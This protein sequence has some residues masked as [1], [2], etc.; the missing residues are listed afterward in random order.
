MSSMGYAGRPPSLT[1]SSYRS[2][3]STSEGVP[4]CVE[5]ALEGNGEGEDRPGAD[6]AATF[7]KRVLNSLRSSG[8]GLA[9]LVSW[10]ALSLPGTVR[11]LRVQRTVGRCDKTTEGTLYLRRWMKRSGRF[12]GSSTSIS[13]SS[14][15]WA[16]LSV[17]ASRYRSNSASVKATRS[18]ARTTGRLEEGSPILPFTA[19]K[20]QNGGGWR[21]LR[22][23]I[24][25][26][27]PGLHEYF[28]SSSSMI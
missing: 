1:S 14:S 13:T 9:A 8:R 20:V 5:V 3:S 2:F 6:W 12:S 21:W 27:K 16:P 7:D 23:N 15:P 26:M 24:N 25:G 19:N 10:C 11:T 18:Q 28:D 22:I 17:W 4:G